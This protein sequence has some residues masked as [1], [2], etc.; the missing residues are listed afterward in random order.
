MKRKLLQLR[1]K[2]AVLIFALTIMGIIGA[3]L[4]IKT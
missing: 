1:T 2:D 4:S 3:A